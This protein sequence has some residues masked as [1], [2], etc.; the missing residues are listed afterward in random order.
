MKDKGSVVVKIDKIKKDKQTVTVPV[1]QI[2]NSP[3]IFAEVDKEEGIEYKKE[4]ELIITEKPQAAMKVAYALSDNPIKKV[5]QGV[6]YF[7]LYRNGKKIIVGCAVGH[8]FGLDEAEKRKKDEFTYN[9]EWKPSYTKKNSAF[10][11]K[12]YAVL[13]ALAKNAS[14]FVVATD[15]DIEGEVIGLNVLKYI[16]KQKD[17]HRMKFSTLT[18]E[19][20][21]NAYDNAMKHLDWG[22]AYAG[23]AR[24]YL[25][26]LYGINLSRALM[27]A[28]KKAGGFKILSIGRVQG[29]TLSLIVEKEK[30]IA[31][32]KSHTYWNISLEVSNSHSLSVK[33]PKD[34]TKK[35]ELE[36]FKKLKGKKGEAVTEKSNEKL[37]TQPPF[38]L[39]TLQMESYRLF[40]LSPA[41]TLATAQKL[42]LE[43]LIS[44]PRTSSQKLPE[45]IGYAGI[46][47]KLSKIFPEL[48]KIAT[49]KKPAEGNKSD[50]AH[51]SIYPTGE[52]PGSLESEEMNL[53]ELIVRRFLSC[54]A[55]PALIENKKI[56]V[57]VEIHEFSTRGLKILEKGWLGIYPA[58]M[59]EKEL[60]DV[61]GPVTVNEVKIDEKETMPPKRFTAA[62]LVS[63][64][65]KRNL[66]TKSTRAAIIETLFNR[67]YVFDK[68]IK[69][70]PLGIS[71]TETLQ[72][73]C[74]L[75]LD[76]ELTRNFEKEMEAIRKSKKGE[77]EKD[78]IINDAKKVLK[79]IYETFKKNEVKIGK[80]LLGARNEEIEREKEA[81]KMVP[82]PKCKA[83]MLIIKK[84]KG[85]RFLA[86]N[87]YP[88]CK[89]TFSLPPFGGIK[90]A[91][92]ICDKCGWPMLM[93]LK[94]GSSP[95]LFC[96]NP[97]CPSRTK[98]TEAK[99]ETASA[100]AAESK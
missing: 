78:K 80:D 73:N 12:Y 92:K 81:S 70:T 89:T 41:Q 38:D 71:V 93:A 60:P 63:E 75:I 15:Y 95:W 69:A 19:E 55:K 59:E 7:E 18:K 3:Q 20:L 2:D 40:S 84:W 45:S 32:F 31:A 27:Q 56:K 52:K 1:K 43:G 24:H 42:Y 64:L 10:T 66:G 23:E 77:Q 97:V 100:P 36:K 46:I 33:Y 79:K 14:S 57:S 58:R 11:K 21:S 13:A 50:P 26:W 9:L 29:P 17:A 44:Y 37:F 16:C 51:P 83:G 61:N 8:L 6:P 72:K 88:D 48:A 62:S 86:C 49:E 30:S 82:C 35:D 34:I 53:Y 67:G 65:S 99:T 90:V 74:P 25:D 54:F 94:M 4:T 39:T 47:K 28:M 98:K 68:S 87:K 91:E 5:I 22:Q 96:F 85:K 76:E